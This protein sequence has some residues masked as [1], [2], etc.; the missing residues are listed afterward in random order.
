VA[1]YDILGRGYAAMRRP[2]PRIAE[3]IEAALGDAQ[4]VVNIGAGTGSY[5]PAGRTMLAI[6][7]S[8]MMIR[9]R[10]AHAAPCIRATAEALPLGAN[11]VDAAM[12]I[13][14]VHHWTDPERGLAEMRRVARK[15]VILLTWV[16]DSPSFWLTADYFPEIP[17]EDG[18]IFPETAELTSLLERVIGTAQIMPLPIPHDCADGFLCAYW[19][20]PEAY[21]RAEVRGAISSFARFDPARGLT[22]LR[23]D[24][25]T[26]RWAERNRHLLSLCELDL[27]YRLILC[28]ID[29]A[30]R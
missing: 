8:D 12:A 22:R 5:E 20:R 1:K 4:T 2:E 28:E 15:R 25:E 17:A 18:R 16:P 27:G 9:Q 14:T 23:D 13:L 30:D 7:P 26:G 21:L 24:I 29:G 19:R 6:E 3:A 10:S 11:A